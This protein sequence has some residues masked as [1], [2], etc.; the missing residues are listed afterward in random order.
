MSILKPRIIDFHSLPICRCPNDN[1]ID[2]RSLFFIVKPEKD[3]PKEDNPIKVTRLIQYSIDDKTGLLCWG[4][5]L[6]HVK[7]NG[8]FMGIN[9]AIKD[10]QVGKESFMDHLKEFYPNNFEWLLFNPEWYLIKDF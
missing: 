7:F 5:D 1:N 2:V 8:N 3:K 9:W 6:A 4:W 10:V